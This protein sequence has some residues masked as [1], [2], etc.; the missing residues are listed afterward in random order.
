MRLNCNA[1]YHGNESWQ[2]ALGC[3]LFDCSTALG[4]ERWWDNINSVGLSLS[5]LLVNIPI[6]GSNV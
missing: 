4:I 1:W 2:V 5:W 3:Q 6:I